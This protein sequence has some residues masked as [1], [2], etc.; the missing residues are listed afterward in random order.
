MSPFIRLEV[1]RAR[2]V[3]HVTRPLSSFVH[4]YLAR[5]GMLAGF[6]D[7][8]PA[9][10]RCVHPLVTLFEKLDAM[11][12]RY[13]REESE[14]DT[15]VRHYEDA[16]QII[17]AAG[18]LPKAGMTAAELAR[19]M[20]DERD[21]AAIPRADD[22]ALALADSAKRMAVERAYARIAPMFWGPRV[23]LDEACATI[24]DWIERASGTG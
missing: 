6:E 10:V 9:A 15:F 18:T 20:L 1:G 24:R 14:P 5:R 11:S 2:V 7:N 12:R 21:I 17:R 19:G 23:P 22:P 16:A 3:P 8:R 4:D 13:A